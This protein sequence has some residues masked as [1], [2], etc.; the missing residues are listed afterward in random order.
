VPGGGKS[1]VKGWSRWVQD[2]FH[3]KIGG[4]AAELRVGA[5]LLP[6]LLYI[7]AIPYRQKFTAGDVWR[8]FDG[9]VPGLSF[10]R[11]REN[12]WPSA[13]VRPVR[14]YRASAA[15]SLK[16]GAGAAFRQNETPVFL[17]VIQGRRG[18][19]EWRAFRQKL[20]RGIEVGLPAILGVDHWNAEQVVFLLLQGALKK[21]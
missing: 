18:L 10:Q 16:V 6:K 13:G 3:L 2:L 7:G 19:K 4:K 14:I 9:F 21:T 1:R 17:P 5:D 20:R 12:L 8:S 11:I 15:G